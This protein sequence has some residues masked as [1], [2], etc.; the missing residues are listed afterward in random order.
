MQL[1][2]E[3]LAVVVLKHRWFRAGFG[4]LAVAAPVAVGPVTAAADFLHFPPPLEQAAAA[5]GRGWQPCWQWRAVT[6][7]SALVCRAGAERDDSI[8]YPSP[9]D[10]APLHYDYPTYGPGVSGSSLSFVVGR[11]HGDDLRPPPHAE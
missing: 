7:A 6:A 1:W 3:R 11:H 8:P 4:V 10:R 9:E 2:P 5:S